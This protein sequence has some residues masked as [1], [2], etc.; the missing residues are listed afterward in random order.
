MS[1]ASREYITQAPAAPVDML[2]RTRE[3]STALEELLAGKEVGWDILALESAEDLERESISP[4]MLQAAGLLGP[5][6]IFVNV[7]FKTEELSGADLA[8][9]EARFD[10]KLIDE[11]VSQIL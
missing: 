4:A 7:T 2:Y 10:L 3:I 9:W 1:L 5:P 6:I 11:T 8:A